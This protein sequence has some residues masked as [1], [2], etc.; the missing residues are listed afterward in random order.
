MNQKRRMVDK[1]ESD[2]KTNMN[3]TIH[4]TGALNVN[5][6]STVTFNKVQSSA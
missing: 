2:L 1:L 5:L 3:M 6:N 4:H